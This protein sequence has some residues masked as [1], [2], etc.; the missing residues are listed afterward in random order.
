MRKNYKILKEIIRVT[1]RIK[2]MVRMYKNEKKNNKNKYFDNCKL[3]FFT[4]ETF[5]LYIF[6]M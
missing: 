2:I 4:F 6:K 5:T 1:R 3:Y